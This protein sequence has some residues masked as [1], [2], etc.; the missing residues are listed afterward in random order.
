L[1]Q[2]GDAKGRWAR[3]FVGFDPSTGFGLPGAPAGNS[4]TEPNDAAHNAAYKPG[5]F[6]RL[7]PFRPV[8]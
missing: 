4:Y 8:P 2:N 3:F 5:D 7:M 1:G 6:P